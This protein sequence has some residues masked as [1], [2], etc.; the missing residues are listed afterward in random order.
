M[1]VAPDLN[2]IDRLLAAYGAYIDSGFGLVQPKVGALSNIL[3]ALDVTLAALWWLSE[4]DD[5]VLGRLIKKV[6]Y[7]GAFAFILTN[8]QTLS[9]TVFK[10]FSTLGLTAGGGG[11]SAEDLMRPGRIAGVGFSAAHPLID[12]AS[13]LTGF[14]EVFV[15]LLTIVL[16]MVAWLLVVLAFFVMSIQLLVTILE[17]K[18]TSLA[19]FTLVPF[20]FWNK[21]SFLAERVLGNVVSS[22]VK[23]MVLAIIVGIGANF[24]D[25]LVA[26]LGEDPDLAAAMTLVLAALTLAAL[27]IFGPSIASGLVSGAPQLGAGAA[28][29]TAAGAAL[30][31]GGG[32]ALGARALG[33]AASGGLAAMRAGTAMGAGASAA[34]RLAQAT[35]GAT[36]AAGVG[37][38]LG[39]VA[40]AAGGAAIQGAGDMAD[41][42]RT[43]LGQSAAQGRVAAWR[44]S[45]GTSAVTGG[46]EAATP[47]VGAGVD[48]AP[49]WAQRLR[50]RPA[51]DISR[52]AAI[53]ALKEGDRQGGAANPD[54]S[55]KEA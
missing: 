3:I 30:M 1:D 15:N 2:I 53:Q 26:T 16:L 24:F 35:S 33:A 47:S 19:G 18:L 36:G 39:G 38:G 37:A 50:A 41:R 7:I 31:L 20:A 42:A 22:G 44:G 45:G 21:S 9:E 10:S 43:A 17:F 55:N 34:Y 51:S 14:P 13:Q 12:K 8:F 54:L 29:G 49:A 23:V 25:P 11:L 6:L 48:V 27:S 4:G 5:N 28:V 52:H 46:A 32:A 40:R